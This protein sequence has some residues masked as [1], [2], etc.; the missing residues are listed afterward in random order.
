MVDD[1]PELKKELSTNVLSVED[2]NNATHKLINYFSNWK[3]LK[4]AVAWILKVKKVLLEVSRQ[5]KQLITL[6]DLEQRLQRAK[7]SF[8]GQCLSPDDLSEAENAIIQFCQWE[9]FSMEISPLKSGRS[10]IKKDS[11]IHKLSPIL[12]DGLLRI[13]GR[14]CKAATPEERKHPVILSKD[15]HI[16]KMILRH[17]HVQSG[18]SG[19]TICSLN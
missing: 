8:V 13:G 2:T 3:R 5:R 15:Q 6:S 18:H 17:I 1:D 11:S 16:S 19:K 4:T 14:L 9:K 12:Q 7:I 10:E